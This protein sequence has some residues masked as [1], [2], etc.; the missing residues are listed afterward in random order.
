M[1]YCHQCHT[2]QSATLPYAVLHHWEFAHRPVCCLVA[3]YLDGLTDKPMLCIAAV[4]PGLLARVPVLARAQ[5]LRVK[6]SKALQAAQA[7]VA[8]ACGRRDGGSVS[9]H[10]A[11]ECRCVRGVCASKTVTVQ[12]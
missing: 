1:L 3:D 6:A 10:H 9:T 2:N 7:K 11:P 8:A 5:E 4:N 12:L